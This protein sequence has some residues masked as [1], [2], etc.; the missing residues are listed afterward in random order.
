MPVFP[1]YITEIVNLMADRRWDMVFQIG[2]QI[3]HPQDRPETGPKS[4]LPLL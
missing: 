2:F 3:I 1:R 4:S